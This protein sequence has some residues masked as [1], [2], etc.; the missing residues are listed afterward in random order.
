MSLFPSALY[1]F[2]LVKKTRKEIEKNDFIDFDIDSIP[3]VYIQRDN[4]NLYVGETTDFHGRFSSHLRDT[5]KT[6]NEIIIIKSQLFNAS[7]IKHIE[8]LLIDYLLADS[9]FNLLN[10]IKGQNIHSYNGIEDVN[11]MF[12]KI[13][14]KLI[15]EG[16][17]SERLEEIHNKFI[18]KYSPFKVLSANQIE[19]CQDILD[20]MITTSESRHLITGDPGTG[21]TIVLT[22]ILYALVYDQETGKDRD[23]LDREDV[24]LVIPQNHSLS[25]YKDL[26]RKVGLHGITVLSPSQFV[27]KAKGKG[28]KYKYVFVDEAHRLKQYFGK[29]ARDLKHLIT[30]DGHTTELELISDYAYHLTVVY[31]QYQ[32]I[33]PADIDTDHFKQ[34]TA[35]YK[36]HILRK[37][38][39]LKSGDQYLA[40]LRKYLQI[41]NDVAVYEK[42]LLKGYDFKVMDS[43]SDLYN[44]INALNEK[45]DLC[46]VVA[47]YSWEWATKN[48]ENLHDITDPITGDEFKW[49]S[50]TKGWINQENSVE[51]IGCIHTI[52]GAD[53]NYVGVIFGDEIDCD[54][55]GEVKGD[56]DL[57]KA[58]IKVN[59]ERYKD[60]NGL[61]IKGTDLNN[62]ELKS[63]IKRI[64]YVLLSRGI[65]GCY[66]FA[67][68]PNMKR[69]LKEIVSI[70]Q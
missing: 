20:A 9:K 69:Y 46:R 68:N 58:K 42:G 19:V 18:Y 38:F 15:A 4:K 13:W 70:S 3:V 31:D 1:S 37:Q 49:N 12:V 62:E 11:N 61:P 23:G 51:E 54:Y 29:Q 25:S 28:D 64:Y 26:I 33:R 34:L 35:D 8:T 43:I 56:Y 65:N 36:K 53:L 50:K 39:R 16:V 57:S 32:T 40:W 22:N 41:A 44:T 24:A 2:E 52:Q 14:D 5:S 6:F 67:T 21:K 27:K 45:H 59:P 30:A 7:S 60:R 48:D 17:A 55:A 63:Y 47:G 66:V 10:K